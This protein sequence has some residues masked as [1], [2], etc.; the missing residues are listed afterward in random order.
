MLSF[1]K[2]NLGTI[3]VLIVLVAIVFLIIRKLVKDK[4]KGVGACGCDCSNCHAGCMH[5]QNPPSE[6]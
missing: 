3:I 6:H 2:A 5:A 4:K 1:L